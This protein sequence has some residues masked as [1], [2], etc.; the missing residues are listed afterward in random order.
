MTGKSSDEE[1]AQQDFGIIPNKIYRKSH[2]ETQGILGL[3]PTGIDEAILN[4][5]LPPPV[6]LTAYGKAVGWY[7]F[8]LIQ[9]IKDRLTKAEARAAAP[10]HREQ[11][12]R[13][14]NKRKYRGRP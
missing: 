7:G 11:S 13:K 12:R 1:P 8:T 5:E 14:S 10:P 6:P 4:K 2:P 9:V 3:S